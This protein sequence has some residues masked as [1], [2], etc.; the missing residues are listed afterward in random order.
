MFH[1]KEMANI[2]IIMTHSLNEDLDDK[3][4][5]STFALDR[6]IS[7]SVASDSAT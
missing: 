7:Q 2:N 3:F 6:D 1:C 5:T 4:A